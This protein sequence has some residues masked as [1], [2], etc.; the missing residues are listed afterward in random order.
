VERLA[1]AVLVVYAGR[2]AAAGDFRSIRRLMTDRPH[3]FNVRSSDDRALAAAL[4]ETPAVFGVELIGDLLAVRTS[5][6]GA[7]SA[8]IAPT[9]RRAGVRLYEV[10]PTDDSLESVFSYLVRR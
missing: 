1:E 10:T 3:R 9:A 7:F 4:L 5:E 8:I 6:F 2:L